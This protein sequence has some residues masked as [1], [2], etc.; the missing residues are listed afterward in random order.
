MPRPQRNPIK[1]GDQFGHWTVLSF[2]GVR[3]YKSVYHCKCSCGKERDVQGVA[4]RRGD[5]KSCG[6]Q[7]WIGYRRNNLEGKQFGKLTVLKLDPAR[8]LGRVRW[9]CQCQCGNI[10]SILS[11]SLTRKCSTSCGCDK[12]EKLRAATLKRYPDYMCRNIPRRYFIATRSN[13]KRRGIAFNL[14]IEEMADQYEKQNRKCYFTNVP[15]GFNTSRG[16][17]N[18]FWGHSASIDRL[19]SSKDYNASNICIV[20]RD[21]NRMKNDFPLDRFIEVCNLVAKNHPLNISL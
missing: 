15:I 6:C 17:P 8:K 19:D 20:H 9:L 21:V 3:N 12:R 4:L 7:R 1:I 5:T 14:T 2:I 11:A 13:A 10:K 18:P 16:N